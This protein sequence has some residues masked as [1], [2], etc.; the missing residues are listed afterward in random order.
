MLGWGGS[1]GGTSAFARPPVQQDE[2]TRPARLR[3]PGLFRQRTV[4]VSSPESPPFRCLRRLYGRRGRAEAQ[5]YIA[6]GVKFLR[7][8]PRT[9]FVRRSRWVESGARIESLLAAGGEEGPAA[10]LDTGPMS[11]G[12]DQLDDSGSMGEPP[13][14][15]VL[16]DELFN[17]VSTQEASQGVIC[18]FPM[19]S[20]RGV[21]C[22]ATSK[23]VVVLDAVQDSINIG[24]ILR[25]MEAFKAGTLIS[26]KGTTDLYNPKVVRCSMGAVVRGGLQL[27]AADDVP[28]LQRL[29]RGY[30]IF[31]TCMDGQVE[32]CGLAAELTG[33][34]AFVFGNEARGVSGEVLDIA[35]VRLRISMAEQVESL[36]VGVSVGIILHA[37][38]GG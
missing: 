33:K 14:I 10:L 37:A 26:L 8:S 22:W 17:L 6:E 31:A 28:E 4:E 25:T 19:P 1:I 13:G 38:A 36:N 7:M 20:G 9:V 3:S 27:L 30:R 29:L 16:A 32:P 34:D 11:W 21:Q 23:R 35:D 18:I 24:V 2:K 5:R 15:C 12:A